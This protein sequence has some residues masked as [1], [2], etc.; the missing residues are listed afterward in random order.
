[1]KE[2]IE[3][4]VK[5]TEEKTKITLTVYYKTKKT[6]QLLLRNRPTTIKS[7]LQDD[8]VIY[9][10]TCNSKECG[11]CK[12]IGMTRTTLSR[13]L[14]CHLNNGAIKQHYTGR[15]HNQLSRQHLTDNT[16]ILDRESDPRRLYIL[17]AIYILTKQPTINIQTNNLQTLPTLKRRAC[18][19]A[20][21]PP[22]RS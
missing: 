8:H 21:P 4:N 20:E 2:I 10:H 15:H 12:Y 7:P 9:E 22:I 19:R 14:T 18:Q 16:I 1:M 13:R 3:K 6:S 5:P 17:E 11:P